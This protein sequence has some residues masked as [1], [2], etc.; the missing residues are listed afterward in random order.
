MAILL[1]ELP[2][3]A[4]SGYPG[5]EA[6]AWY[7]MLVPGGTPKSVVERIRNETLTALQHLDVQTAMARQGLAPETSTPAALAERIKRESGMY[8]ALIRDAGIRAE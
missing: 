8:A 2:T 6:D 5:F 7:A 4:E 3:V 1:P